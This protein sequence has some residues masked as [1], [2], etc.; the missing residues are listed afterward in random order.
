MFGKELF[1]WFT[2][3]FMCVIRSFLVLRV[4][5]WI[6]LYKFLIIAYL[7]LIKELFKNIVVMATALETEKH[8]V[9]FFLA[10]SMYV[11]LCIAQ[12]LDNRL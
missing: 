2:V 9:F 3:Q 4:G 8:F 11:R 5:C 10:D 7:L 6:G 12:K 1:V